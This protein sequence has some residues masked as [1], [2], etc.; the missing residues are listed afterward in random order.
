MDGS[1]PTAAN[2]YCV[3]VRRRWMTSRIS[4]TDE[5]ASHSRFGNSPNHL[6]HLLSHF[7]ALDPGSQRERE[8]TGK[9]YRENN[10]VN[11]ERRKF[12]GV[13]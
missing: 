6:Y 4:L 13:K 9:P 1:L 7:E 10:R 2:P 8:V 5:T 12:R 3:Q 11:I